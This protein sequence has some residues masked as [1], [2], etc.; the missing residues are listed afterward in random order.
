M[1]GRHPVLTAWLALVVMLACTM[2]GFAEDKKPAE[3]AEAKKEEKKA[4][5][6]APPPAPPDI[7]QVQIQVWITETNE[8]GLRNIGTNLNYTRFVRQVEQSGSVQ[9]VVTNVFDPLNDFGQVTMP[10]PTAPGPNT[11]Q[12]PLRPDEAG[13]P[14]IQDRRGMGLE[15]EVINTGYG[16]IDGIFQGEATRT[17]VDLISKPE[18]LVVNGAQAVINAGGKIPYQDVTYP[19]GSP[20]LQVQFREIG[21]NLDITP[22]ILPD[23]FVQM[24]IAKLEVTDIARIE[25]LRG[26]DLP[27][28]STRSQTGFVYV[29][30]GKTLVIGGLSSRITRH[31]ER[32]V[33]IVGPTRPRSAAPRTS[34]AW[35][36][37]WRRTTPRRSSAR[38]RTWS[39]TSSASTAAT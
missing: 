4:E 31:S 36:Y 18:L 9:Q 2:P 13:N 30:N 10:A 35:T 15:A 12:P 11:F 1:M 32:R 28:F 27:V 29:P 20:Q 24:N 21:V 5:K 7:R 22:Q 23:D 3:K 17:D 19:K 33:P 34:S 39:S 26:V 6:P 16:T 14:G 8:Q 38:S 25:N 37:S